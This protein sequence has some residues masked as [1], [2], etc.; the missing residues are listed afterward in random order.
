MITATQN[1][2]LPSFSLVL[3]TTKAPRAVERKAEKR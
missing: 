2:Q 3:G 1:A